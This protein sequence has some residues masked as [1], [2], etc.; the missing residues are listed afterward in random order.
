[1]RKPV[2]TGEN[3]E[4]LGLR[5]L[6]FLAAEPDRFGRFLALTGI[7]PTEI[8]DQAKD[9]SFLGAVLDYLLS[10]EDLLLS[11]CAAEKID[12]LVPA[13]A[14]SRLPGAPVYD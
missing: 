10:D 4:T 11:F 2:L 6:A 13:A 7:G 14:R 12:P 1:M 8:R 3:A 9:P 5:C